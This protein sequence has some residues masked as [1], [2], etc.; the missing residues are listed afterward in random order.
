MANEEHHE[1]PKKG[2]REPLTPAK[3]SRL[4]RLYEA[5]Q[6]KAS[7][8][9]PNYDYAAELLA[10]CVIGNP[11]ND[12]FVKTYIENLQKK[13]NNNRTGASLAQLRERGAAQRGEKSP[14]Q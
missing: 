2:G 4:D 13:Y 8:L 14:G 12:V 1:A 5:A 10:Q 11:G 7:G 9:K 6:K 3:R